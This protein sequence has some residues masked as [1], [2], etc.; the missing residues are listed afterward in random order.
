VR[1]RQAI[2]ALV[3]EVRRFIA[4]AILFN[5]SVAADLSLNASDLQCL[6]LLELEGAATPGELARC[7]SLTTG[8]VT[9]LLDRLERA[10]YVHREPNPNDRRSS[11]VRPDRARLRQL[12]RIYRAKGE[13]LVRVLSQFNE[14]ELRTILDFFRKVNQQDKAESGG[15]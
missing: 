14:A 12:E 6:G 5:E 4:G 2:E 7:A 8:G 1:R 10:G 3:V 15:V 11:I 13:A 9:V